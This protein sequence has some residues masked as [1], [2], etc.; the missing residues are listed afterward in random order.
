MDIIVRS[1]GIVAMH[2]VPLQ[3]YL[4]GLKRAKGALNMLTSSSE[5]QRNTHTHTHT[6]T[7]SNSNSNTA[8]PSSRR[9]VPSISVRSN[10]GEQQREQEPNISFSAVAAEA[11]A[12]AQ[13]A[14]DTYIRSQEQQ[15]SFDQEAETLTFI[16]GGSKPPPPPPPPPPKPERE[17]FLSMR[18]ERFVSDVRGGRSFTPLMDMSLEYVRD[19][20]FRL[21]K[22]RL[23]LSAF[24]LSV[25][26]AKNKENEQACCINK[27]ATPFWFLVC[28]FAISWVV[29]IPFYD[30][31]AP[32]S[33]HE[34]SHLDSVFDVLFL[35]TLAFSVGCAAQ[36]IINL[37]V[38]Y[39][40]TDPTEHVCV[41]NLNYIR[42]RLL[43]PTVFYA[44]AMLHLN[45]EHELT[46]Y[47][48]AIFD[49]HKSMLVVAYV[50]YFL[51]MHFTYW[52]PAAYF[53]AFCFILIARAVE[54]AI[55]LSKSMRLV[56]IIMLRLPS[57][58]TITFLLVV[59]LR[60]YRNGE[61]IS[62]IDGRVFPSSFHSLVFIIA[63]LFY[64]I[65]KTCMW[66]KD[67]LRSIDSVA[68]QNS[69]SLPVAIMNW[70]YLTNMTVLASNAIDIVFTLAIMLSPD[71]LALLS[72][73]TAKSSL[74]RIV[75]LLD[76]RD[77][78]PPEVEITPT[79]TAS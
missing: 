52:H 26:R 77:D 10:N 23:A 31:L 61:I 5:L 63:A 15:Q 55:V 74:Q 43:L 47:L 18:L 49:M 70:E 28:M 46:P 9:S 17:R 36:C 75:E 56:I 6:H 57:F 50:F 59:W 11:A 4:S 48:F 25:A 64:L 79:H 8:S 51:S 14:N 7:N 65:T 1:F 38:A 42:N 13:A 41:F 24:N 40:N 32:S 12:A 30:L 39:F 69:I 78:V 29:Y 67:S 66:S 2:T 68:S 33:K 72:S 44:F 37:L 62:K 20:N 35:S 21:A 19:S 16:D 34:N 22:L 45:I 76:E 73:H 53:A 27:S 60:K 71:Q 54:V 3:L 58:L